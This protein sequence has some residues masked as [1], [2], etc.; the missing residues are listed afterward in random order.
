MWKIVRSCVLFCKE[1]DI[2]ADVVL[3][4]GNVHH[5]KRFAIEHGPDGLSC[6]FSAWDVE[7]F[8]FESRPGRLNRGRCPV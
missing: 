3:Y 6:N 4:V 1:V 5:R 7:D 2:G 8:R